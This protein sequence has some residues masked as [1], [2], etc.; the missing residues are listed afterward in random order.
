MTTMYS[1]VATPQRQKGY[2]ENDRVT[3][4]RK[5]RRNVMRK[6]G[7]CRRGGGG[8]C[9]ARQGGADTN[10]DTALHVPSDS[11]ESFLKDLDQTPKL[12]V[13]TDFPL[14][15]LEA[16]A[17]NARHN[18]ESVANAKHM[19]E[20]TTCSYDDEFV[21]LNFEEIAFYEALVELKSN[22]EED[23]EKNSGKNKKKKQ[24]GAVLSK[25]FDF[26]VD[27]VVEVQ[28]VLCRRNSLPGRV[29]VILKASLEPVSI[30]VDEAA[31]A[32]GLQSVTKRVSAVYQEAYK[33]SYQQFL[34]A[35]SKICD[36][37]D[38]DTLKLF[39]QSEIL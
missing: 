28:G 23:K 26:G 17:E 12:A 10:T 3:P 21:P 8:V 29:R 16:V 11:G 31:L 2:S 32:S 38:C 34:D 13:V 22:E 24:K 30:E 35:H 18:D 20:T 5:I 15:L 36:A 9:V 7:R 39:G 37:V 1:R 6:Q 19:L 14:K 27:D 33:L 25:K 4:R